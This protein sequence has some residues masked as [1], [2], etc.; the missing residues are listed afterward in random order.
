MNVLAIGTLTGK[1]I[2][3]HLEAEGKAIAALR[4]EGLIRDF[5]LKADRTGPIL[6]LNDVDG[7]KAAERLKTLPFIEE[8]LVTFEYVELETLAERHARAEGES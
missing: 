1:D 2:H 3:P 4:E 5:F 8:D 7:E 6:I